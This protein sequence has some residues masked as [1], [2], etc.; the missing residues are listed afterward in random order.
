MISLFVSFSYAST[1]YDIQA[2][3]A[4]SA[5]NTNETVI[6]YGYLINITSNS[7]ANT[8]SY[9]Q[10][11][12]ISVYMLNSTNHTLSTYTLY[13]NNNGSFYSNSSLYL[14]NTTTITAPGSTGDYTIAVNYTGT[15]N[16]TWSSRLPI[17]VMSKQ[18]DE[19]T[20]K[21]NK[22]SF[23]ASELM[24]LTIRA[25]QTN[26]DNTIGIINVPI[27]GSMRRYNDSSLLST[28]NCTTDSDGKCYATLTAPAAAGKYL[29]EANNFIG[30]MG[31][32]VVPFDV[33][34]YV[35]DSTGKNY[36][37]VFRTGEP[38]LVEVRV[39]YNSTNPT[40]AF[41]A[42][43]GIMNL[44]GGVKQNMTSVLLNITNGFVNSLSFTI[45]NTFSAGSVYTA[46]I[47]VSD[48]T[49]SVTKTVSFEVR[50]WTFTFAKRKSN[51]GFEYGY[52]VFPNTTM[53]FQLFPTERENGTL[54]KNLTGDNTTIALKN[55]LGIQLSN[56]S[57]SYNASCGSIDCY[58]FNLT[59]PVTV[60]NYI[61]SVVVNYSGVVIVQDRTVKITDTLA[62]I[63]SADSEGLIKELFG[64]TEYIYVKVSAKNK[65]SSVNV[66]DVNFSTLVYENG[67]VITY[68]MASGN[69]TNISDS[70]FEWVW[71][72]SSSLLRLD[73]PQTGGIYVLEMYTNNRSAYATTKFAI[74]PYDICSQAKAT[75]DTSTVDYWWQFRTTDTIYFQITVNEAQ[76]PSGKILNTTAAVNGTYGIGTACSFD[77]TKK[78]AANN[79]TITVEK[80]LNTYGNKEESMNATASICQSTDNSGGYL[81]TVKADD[82]KWDGGNHVV[83]FKA[84][85]PLRN[86]TDRGL[87]F[88]DA[89]AFY[90]YGWA[91]SWYNKNDAN[92]SLNVRLYEA[93]SGWWNS[94]TG[95]SGSMTIEKINN[96]GS[97]GE[98][99]WPPVQYP[100]NTSGL[101][102]TAIT[103]GTG[104]MTVP[105]NKTN[106]GSWKSGQYGVVVKATVNGETDY[107]ELWFSVRKWDAYGTPV[108]ISGNNYVYKN[109]FN[110]REN[111]S[112]YVRLYDAGSWSDSGGTTIGNVTLRV[113]TVNDYS[114]WPASEISSGTYN[115]TVASV[116]KSS[117][118]YSDSNAA[119]N[120]PNHVINIS[121]AGQWDSGWYSVVIDINGTETG[122]G[123]FN[124]V[125]FQVYTNPVNSTG[126]SNYYFTGTAPIYFNVT[127]TKNWKPSY[128]A[129]DFVN[130]TVDDAVV[131]VWQSSTSTTLE[132]NYPE[133][134]NITQMYVNGS[135]IIALN[136]STAW[137]SGWYYGDLKMKDADNATGKGWL[138]FS[139]KPFRVSTTGSS[140]VSTR[141][142]LSLN[143][144]ILEPYYFADT[145]RF[146]NYTIERITETI[147]SY[148]SRTATQHS[149]VPLGNFTQNKS[150]NITPANGR[151]TPGW[152]YISIIVKD[153]NTNSTE[154]QW[155]SFQALPFQSSVSRT[156]AAS[157]GPNTNVTVNIT[158]T[159]PIT[160]ARTTGN[161]S[162]AYYWGWPSK[163]QYRFVIG[164]C[165]SLTSTSCMI[166]GSSIVNITP[167]SGGWEEGY[168]YMYFNFV[169][170]TDSSVVMDTWNG[171]YFEVRQPVTGN[172]YGVDRNTNYVWRYAQ[173][174]NVTMYLYSLRNLNS[175][176]VAVN[177][178]NVQYALSDSNC[179]S[180][181]CRTY[182]DAA[183]NVMLR[184]HNNNTLF[185][186]SGVN[187]TEDGFIRINSSGSAW[188]K[189][190]YYVRVSVS[191]GGDTATIK[192]GYFRISD[193]TVPVVTL[194]S[195]ALNTVVSGTTF[196]VSATTSENVR[197]NAA[198]QDYGT[199]YAQD[200]GSQD[201]IGNGSAAVCN[202]T[203]YSNA[204]T[205]YTDYIYDYS[206]WVSYGPGRSGPY[207]SV[208]PGGTISTGG[209]THTATVTTSY[210]DNQYYAVKVSCYDEDWNWAGNG[211]VILVNRT[212]P[213]AI[214]ITA[215]TNTT[216]YTTN[217]SLSYIANGT[218]KDRCYYSLN[219]GSS[220][221]LANSTFGCTNITFTA[222][223]GSNNVRVYVNSTAGTSNSSIVYFSVN[224]T[225]VNVTFA[226]PTPAMNASV[227]SNNVTINVTTNI[228]VSN[229]FL[230]WNGVNETMQNIT[231][232]SWYV[233]KYNLTNGNYS[234]IV[235]VN[236]NT[237][238]NWTEKRLVYMNMTIVPTSG[239]V[240]N[241]D[242][243]F[244]GGTYNL[245]D[246]INIS[247][248]NV[249]LN[250]NF[251]VLKGNGSGTGI[252]SVGFSNVTIKYCNVLNFSIG[253]RLQGNNLTVQNNSIY[254]NTAGINITSSVSANISLN[255]IY[256]NSLY[257][258]VNNQSGGITIIRNWWGTTNITAV[259]DTIHDFYNDSGFGIANFTTVLPGPAR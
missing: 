102:A 89:R 186:S 247:S 67:T 252:L 158:L 226:S 149:Y 187:I 25:V 70:T 198:I 12:T 37:N 150:I 19:I 231:L 55:S 74:N 26:G 116:N 31:F 236:N 242:V 13:T 237:R 109:S 251:A 214:A 259:N 166:N 136:R 124:I 58:D 238:L 94:G 18:V 258:F 63:F 210:M 45:D 205:Y 248:V 234:F 176:A 1:I 48:G 153:N 121:K 65:T 20:I 33:D 79:L 16:T 216:Y 182:Q 111:V 49:N 69:L 146:A 15:S 64:P 41:N 57:I 14:T 42:S 208:Y 143:I 117:P 52:T 68:S 246:G 28:F 5:Y 72:S 96:Y 97:F 115:S 75:S 139:V 6:I 8:S 93:G 148:N 86:T 201:S 77:T 91:N 85:D 189:G 24:S 119:Q 43:G 170:S 254:N 183:W 244:A 212:V 218:N 204:T 141:T 161:L 38:G 211:T 224:S 207:T 130:T 215:P 190:N 179:W 165:D 82:N 46:N 126:A 220:I 133:D 34:L 196:T 225:P 250:C 227:N 50:D 209:T 162:S 90:I 10:N 11:A 56:T 120:Y 44:T 180:D 98:W 62:S 147:W 135:A 203:T 257:N 66:T 154:E 103:T 185:T 108:E 17:R 167:P 51:S 21:A 128:I 73:P 137:P 2:L 184:H 194:T 95:L 157:I 229:A 84:T 195:P 230:E 88:F 255:N 110:S 175:V 27:N 129:T 61:V 32:S 39:S 54:I 87:G 76:N 191:S 144:S 156:S 107:G 3:T 200:C 181:T 118:W 60:D 240:I 172:M 106:D 125:N 239:L 221:S 134:F 206:R 131:R 78:Q 152:R 202:R 101:N 155:Y 100:Y 22:A 174:D 140:I 159:D 83:F 114:K 173:N 245:S 35:K 178:T 188:A 36:K 197:C 4:K 29:I 9:V 163:T 81:C 241:S 199:Y 169:D 59:S 177:V 112:L 228:N 138:Y 160:G 171:I 217:V 193:M 23:Y 113:K 127:T 249:T 235:Y 223:E 40:G 219:G 151:W 222:A 80:V 233:N 145:K 164:S 142:N 99:I 104:T 253:L 92:I 256:N 122:Y 243:T 123:W 192:N 232:S 213:L 47:S 30:Y 71:N 53:F 105:V 132:Y 168:R 7:T